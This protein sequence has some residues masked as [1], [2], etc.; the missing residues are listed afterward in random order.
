MR[1]Y[2]SERPLAMIPSLAIHMDRDA[3][4]GHDLVRQKEIVPLYGLEEAPDL[5]SIVAEDLGLRRADI[6]AHD[7]MLYNTEPPRLWGAQNEFLSA[8]KLDDL[9]CAFASLEGF[10][11]AH[12]SDSIPVHIVLDNEEI[13]SSTMQG[14]CGTFVRDTL[15]RIAEVLGWS[16]Q[17]YLT[18]VAE[19]FMLSA[20]NAHAAHPNHM[21]CADPV[22]YPK[23][24]GGPVVKFS[25]AQT[26]ATDAVS[27]AVVRRAAE[28]AGI[29]LQSFVNNS[30]VRGGRTLGNIFVQQVSAHTADVGIAQLAMHS[31]YETCGSADIEALTALCRTIYSTKLCEEAPGRFSVSVS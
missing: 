22:T 5:L 27:A 29:A 13:G 30:D 26:Y 3:N 28:L 23:L 17:D 4:H 15:M 7:L 16:E 12:E 21:D 2:A 31:P 9:A 6:L 10:V 18:A 19:S 11:S 8:E 1:L 24:N 25:G 20:D 14:A